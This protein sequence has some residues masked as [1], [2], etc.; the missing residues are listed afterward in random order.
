M[1]ASSREVLEVLERRTVFDC[2]G[3]NGDTK[4]VVIWTG[5][6]AKSPPT[7]TLSVKK[8]KPKVYALIIWVITLEGC[9]KGGAPYADSDLQ[10]E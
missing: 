1:G 4:A 7:G 6:D 3:A 5:S 10:R 8:T 9:S 2:S